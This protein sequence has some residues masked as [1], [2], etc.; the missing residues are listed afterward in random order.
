MTITIKRL[1]SGFYS[2]W[3]DVTWIDAACSTLSMA[4][5]KA[6]AIVQAE[7]KRQNKKNVFE[8]ISVVVA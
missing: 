7:N 5:E 6:S 1:P 3:A 8:N 2:V 4:K